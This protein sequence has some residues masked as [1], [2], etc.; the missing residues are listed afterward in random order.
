MIRVKSGSPT[1]PPRT[2]TGWGTQTQKNQ[3][4]DGREGVAAVRHRKER[5]KNGKSA[6]LGVYSGRRID[7]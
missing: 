3:G 2:Q 6:F 5:K 7:F 1:S 4:S